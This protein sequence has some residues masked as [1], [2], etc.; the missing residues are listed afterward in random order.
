MALKINIR[1]VSL[2]LHII[3]STLWP[4]RNFTPPTLYSSHTGLHLVPEWAPF[5]PVLEIHLVCLLCPGAIRPHMSAQTSLPPLGQFHGHATWADP[6]ACTEKG[7]TLGLML[8]SLNPG[9][10][11]NQG[12]LV[13]ILHWAYSQPCLQGSLLWPPECSNTLY[14]LEEHAHSVIPLNTANILT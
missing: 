13:F 1:I 2:A 9:I 3:L 8:C 14:R 6:Q 10:L 12:P 5:L 7:S 4:H 11:L